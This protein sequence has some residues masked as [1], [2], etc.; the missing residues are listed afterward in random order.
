MNNTSWKY[1][2]ILAAVA[3]ILCCICIFL[4]LAGIVFSRSVSHRNQL[5]PTTVNTQT[6]L[7][8]TTLT[9]TRSLKPNQAP[10]L[11]GPLYVG[12]GLGVSRNEM[13]EKYKTAGYT[14]DQP[15]ELNNMEVVIGTNTSLCK[16]SKC[17][18]VALWGPQ[19]NLL[20]ISLF[21]P[22]V[23]YRT[24]PIVIDVIKPFSNWVLIEE[25]PGVLYSASSLNKDRSTEIVRN[26][27]SFKT[28]Y[29]ASTNSAIVILSK[30]RP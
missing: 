15:T 2:I 17:A 3:T 25:I 28:T 13:I 8:P 20:A 12:L 24:M 19:D 27:Y 4:A 14:F 9:P 16:E 5:E 11:P 22:I 7:I 30:P 6:P 29:Q 21:V 1:V 18:L 23:D 26:N 10:L